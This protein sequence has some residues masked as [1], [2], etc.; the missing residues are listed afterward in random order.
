MPP[1]M[2]A[3]DY[4]AINRKQ[5][6][7]WA[8]GDYAAFASHIVLLPER[9]VDLADIRAGSRV[10]DVAGGSGNTALAAARAEAEVTTLDYVPEL[11]VRAAERARPGGLPIELVEGDAEHLPFADA[12]FDTVISA[13]GVMFAPDQE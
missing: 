7:T 1:T 5:Q 9:L 3:P 13:V 8:S 6:A 11:L 4:E 2:L 12:S 10:L